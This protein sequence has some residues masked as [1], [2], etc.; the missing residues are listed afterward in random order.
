MTTVAP[1]STTQ[2]SAVTSSTTPPTTS[3]PPP[4]PPP[5]VVDTPS[6]TSPELPHPGNLESKPQVIPNS[7]HP[8]PQPSSKLQAFSQFSLSSLPYPEL[9]ISFAGDTELTLPTDSTRLFASTWP[10]PSAGQKFL[11]QWEKLSGPNQGS[12]EGIDKDQLHLSGVSFW[13][14]GGG[15]C[16]SWRLCSWWLGHTC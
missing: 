13:G 11:F 4:P 5:N 3:P 1:V 9:T 14:G 7:K 2:T 10:P 16:V 6:T 12:L 15:V 8:Q